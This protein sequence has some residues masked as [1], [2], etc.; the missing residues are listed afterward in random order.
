MVNIDKEIEDIERQIKQTKGEIEKITGKSYFGLILAVFVLAGICILIVWLVTKEKDTGTGTGGGGGGGGKKHY[1]YNVNKAKHCSAT[2]FNICD[3][4]DGGYCVKKS[5]IKSQNSK[6]CLQGECD[7]ADKTWKCPAN[8]NTKNI[9]LNYTN[10]AQ[11]FGSNIEETP[12]WGCGE[13]KGQCGSDWN[14]CLKIKLTPT[15]QE[16]HTT[17]GDL[18]AEIRNKYHGQARKFC[19]D[20]ENCGGFVSYLDRKTQGFQDSKWA[21]MDQSICFK[22]NMNDSRPSDCKKSSYCEC[23][24]KS[25]G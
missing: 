7:K 22:K 14:G 20:N 13:N 18:P 16:Q 23:H 11:Y 1:T 12:L 25:E 15:E 19:N 9:R 10:L 21:L 5:G 8:S 24:I 2:D 3:D 17:P 6:C 4:S